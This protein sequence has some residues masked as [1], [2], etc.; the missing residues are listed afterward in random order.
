ML[1][2]FSKRDFILIVTRGRGSALIGRNSLRLRQFA[3]LGGLM[4][5]GHQY[6][7][8]GDLHFTIRRK[9][10]STC[11]VSNK[12]FRHPLFLPC[13]NKRGSKVLCK[14]EPFSS[15]NGLNHG[16]RPIVLYTCATQYCKLLLNLRLDRLGLGVSRGNFIFYRLFATPVATNRSADNEDNR[17]DNNE[18]FR[19][20]AT[21]GG[22]TRRGFLPSRV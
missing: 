14:V 1:K 19:G 2:F 13:D 15:M 12:L 21:K 6:F 5:L 17:R 16:V 7:R 10:I 4:K 18:Y 22:V 3:L 9:D 20:V 8:R 11:R